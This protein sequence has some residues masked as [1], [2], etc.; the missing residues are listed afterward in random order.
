MFAYRAPLGVGR[1][2]YPRRAVAVITLASLLFF[3]TFALSDRIRRSW[4]WSDHLWPRLGTD[5]DDALQPT[6][7]QTTEL[8]KNPKIALE[9]HLMS[10]CPDARA[11]LQQL[12]VPSMEQISDMVDFRVSFIGS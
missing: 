1:R 8:R 5:H 10:K 9:A 4:P 7:T 6:P 11:C 2:L 12:V 3:M